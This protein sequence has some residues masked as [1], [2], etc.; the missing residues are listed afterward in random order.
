MWG[1]RAL[2]GVVATSRTSVSPGE[3]ERIAGDHLDAVELVFCAGSPSDV[4][5]G[6]RRLTGDEEGDVGD[7]EGSGRCAEHV[8]SCLVVCSSSSENYPNGIRPV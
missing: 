8:A 4:V 6:R 1:G 2:T 3:R 7:A 5:V